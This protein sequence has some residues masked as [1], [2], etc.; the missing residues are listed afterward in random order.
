MCFPPIVFSCYHEI[1][2]ILLELAKSENIL[3]PLKLLETAQSSE[4]DSNINRAKFVL[5]KN[6]Q[7]RKKLHYLTI[8]WWHAHN[9]A[10][11]T[12]LHS[13]PCKTVRH[14]D[15]ATLDAGDD[16]Q[17]YQI[18][19]TTRTLAIVLSDVQINPKTLHSLVISDSIPDGQMY[20]IFWRFR[21][22]NYFV[23]IT[24]KFFVSFSKFFRLL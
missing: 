2:L 22:P 13:F 14:T 1:F 7:K 3:F 6:K 16:E 9:N 10:K 18:T 12:C 20:S 4:N 8:G 24:C 23:G 17:Y 21:F 19:A 5:T 11:N 15:I